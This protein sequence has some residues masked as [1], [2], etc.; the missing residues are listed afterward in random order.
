MNPDHTHI[1]PQAGFFQLGNSWG[2]WGLVTRLLHWISAAVILFLIGLGL[3]MTGEAVAADV[4]VQFGL[5]QTH[6]A[7]G[8]VAFSLGV[9]R[10]LW[11]VASPTPDL[12]DETGPAM[13][14]LAHGGH[15]ALYVLVIAM[16]VT[17][18]L[19]AS[20]SPLQDQYGIPTLLTLEYLLGPETSAPLIAW[21]GW[22]NGVLLE[23]PDPFVPGSEELYKA[24]RAAHHY[25]AFALMAL[26]AGHVLAA[27]KHGLINRDGVLSRMVRG[28]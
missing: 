5:V 14:M 17:G 12:P 2:S 16:P 11:R 19:M 18:W 26:I 8:I 7:W 21:L 10:I 23:V 1:D 28:R 27:L 13:R 3:Y 4:Y 6:K 22:E 9:L 15:V 24:F 25:G 20:A